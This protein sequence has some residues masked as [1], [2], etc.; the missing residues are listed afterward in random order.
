MESTA[1]SGVMSHW[2]GVAAENQVAAPPDWNQS[3]RPA[4][5]GATGGNVLASRAPRVLAR[6]TRMVNIQVRSDER[7]SNLARPLSIPS[8]ASWTTSSAD[9]ALSTN[10]RATRSMVGDHCSTSR[11]IASSS[12]AR[13]SATR[14]ASV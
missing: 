11:E 2:D 4:P 12:P 3:S 9:C 13:S 8:Q 10:E 14:F 6:L 1:L 7:P 5:P